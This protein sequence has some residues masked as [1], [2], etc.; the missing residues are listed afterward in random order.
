MLEAMSDAEVIAAGKRVTRA[1]GDLLLREGLTDTHRAAR[2]AEWIERG[3][4]TQALIWLIGNEATGELGRL[5]FYDAERI[6]GGRPYRDAAGARGGDA[7]RV[8][9]SGS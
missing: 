2:A 8:G 1:A 9:A 7:G 4:I 3:D 5:V 6:Y